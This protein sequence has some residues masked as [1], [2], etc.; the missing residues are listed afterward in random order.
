MASWIAAARSGPASSATASRDSGFGSTHGRRGMQRDPGQQLVVLVAAGGEQQRQRE[1]GDAVDHVGEPAQR[2][3]VEPVGVVDDD[4]QRAEPGGEPVEAVQHGVV[5]LAA[6]RERPGGVGGGAGVG[7]RHVGEQLLDAAERERALEL[8]A[9]GAQHALV[10]DLA[11]QRALADP[12]R[13]ADQQ[14]AAQAVEQ[15]RDRGALGVSFEQSQ[16]NSPGAA[17]CILGSREHLHRRR[18]TPH[19]RGRR[20]VRP[21]AQRAA[22]GAVRAAPP[23]G[24]AARAAR[25]PVPAQQRRH[26]AVHRAACWRSA[27]IW[28]A[29]GT[30]GAIRSS[31][32]GSRAIA[33][34][35]VV[36]GG[37]VVPAV[38]AA[39]GA[40]PGLGRVRPRLPALHGERDLPR[41]RR[42]GHDLR[43]GGQT[44]LMTVGSLSCPLPRC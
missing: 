40:R 32:S 29:T 6:G 17:S 30:G 23:P 7:D 34:I 4:R 16:G 3:L 13:P 24:R 8:R 28:P 42:A 39:G 11:E 31:R 9:A 25:G 19:H 35:A 38:Q 12:G 43:N 15:R 1:V 21:S 37:V 27:S 22:A 26:R 33:I 2:G 5:G 14:A 44:V 20:G 41:R 10:R 18:R 36:G